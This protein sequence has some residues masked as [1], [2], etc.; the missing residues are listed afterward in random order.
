MLLSVRCFDVGNSPGS[1]HNQADAD[2]NVTNL[3]SSADAI[4]F[5]KYMQIKI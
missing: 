3:A 4:H 2:S 5:R 1:F